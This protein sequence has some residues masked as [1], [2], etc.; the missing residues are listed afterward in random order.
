MRELNL[1]RARR[2]R[3][4]SRVVR[5]ACDVLEGRH[6]FAD[7]AFTGG[8]GNWDD[9]ENWD[10]ERLPNSSDNVIIPAA[11]TV[12]VQA[13]A[14]AINSIANAGKLRVVTGGSL[15]IN[16]GG[17]NKD[18]EIAGGTLFTGYS[19]YAK[20]ITGN[21]TW[22]D[23]TLS[24]TGDLDV[25][26][27]AQLS[28]AASKFLDVKL[29]LGGTLTHSGSGALNFVSGNSGLRIKA[30][31]IYTVTGDADFVGLVNSYSTI[32][33]QGTLKKTGPGETLID[34]GELKFVMDGGTVDATAGTIA[35]KTLRGDSFNA[36][37]N[38]S[39][40]A[41][42]RF[43]NGNG[44]WGGTFTGS[45]AGRVEIG[46]G[47][48][49]T[50]Y[51][52]GLEFKFASGLLHVVGGT[53]QGY[54]T[55]AQLKNSGVIQLEG[56]AAKGLTGGPLY[57]SGTVII[58][59]TGEVTLG[60]FNNL[61]GGVLAVGDGVAVTNGIVNNAGTLRKLA[62][63]GEA[64][65]GIFVTVNHDGG[66]VDV[67]GGALATLGSGTV[68]N[69]A[70]DV[71]AGATF[72]P[73]RQ[74]L[75][76]WTGT[77]SGTGGGKVLVDAGGIAAGT[78]GVILKFA[79]G[80]LNFVGGWLAGDTG[81]LRNEGYLQVTGDG[82]RTFRAF[83]E[84]AGT[85]VQDF[86]GGI[87]AYGF[88]V[89]KNLADAVWEVRNTGT[90]N[91]IDFQNAGIF[92]KTGAADNTFN[93]QYTHLAGAKIQVT[94]G[95][96][97][98]GRGSTMLPTQFEVSA[99]ATLDFAPPGAHY[100][101]EGADYTLNGTGTVRISGY[102]ANKDEPNATTG[103]TFNIPTLTFGNGAYFLGP[104]VNKGTITIESGANWAVRCGGGKGF[105]NQGTIN[106][107]GDGQLGIDIVGNFFNDGTYNML[108]DGDIQL[109]NLN[110]GAVPVGFVNTGTFRKSGGTGLS[111]LRDPNGYAIATFNNTGTVEVSSGTLRLG[112]RVE[113]LTRNTA[114]TGTPVELTGGTWIVRTGGT[115]EMPGGTNISP[116][117][118]LPPINTNNATVTLAGG[119]FEQFA[120]VSRNGGTL[121]LADRHD[122]TTSASFTNTG[123]LRPGAGST[124]TI[125][126]GLT[127]GADA[128]LAFPIAD[129]SASGDFGKIAVTGVAAI[130]G[131]SAI[132][133]AGGFA[134][135]PG[136][137]YTLMTF[138][139]RT[140]DFTDT[141]GTSEDL[142][143]A[144]LPTSYVLNATGVT[145]PA[146]LAVDQASITPPA[147]GNVGEPI[148]ISYTV[149]NLST[150]AAFGP[151]TDSIY[152]SRN[153]TFEPTDVLLGRLTYTG[154][155][156]GGAAYAQNATFD[157]PG[158]PDDQYYVI[159]I[160]DSQRQVAQTDRTNDTAASTERVTTAVP[161]L[162][163]G[164]TLN[165]T[166]R[167]GQSKWF[168]VAKPTDID[169]I[170]SAGFTELAQA[171]L[172][173]SAE[174]LPTR[175]VYEFTASDLFDLSRKL[176][177]SLMTDHDYYVLV[178]GRE[179]AGESEA[180]TPFTLRAD[181]V[182][183]EIRSASPNL[184]GNTGIG[185]LVIEGVGF[186]PGSTFQLITPAGAR[187]ASA[188]FFQNPTTVSA[189]FDF[190][191]L[192]AGAYA[193]RV[194]RPDGQ[195]HT[196]NGAVTVAPT[197]A[198]GKAYVN[199][200]APGDIRQGRAFEVVVE[201]GNSGG[202]DIPAPWLTMNVTPGTTWK[203]KGGEAINARHWDFLGTS[204]DGLA[205]V[206][207]PGQRVRLTFEVK[208]ESGSAPDFVVWG[209]TDRQ[210]LTPDEMIELFG[211]TPGEGIWVDVATELANRF[212]TTIQSYAN[213]LA[214]Q[215]SRQSQLGNYVYDVESLI[216]GAVFRALL[217]S[218]P[219]FE[220]G[221]G[222][223]PTT[224]GGVQVIGAT[225][226][227]TA[228]RTL[229]SDPAYVPYDTDPSTDG[230]GSRLPDGRWTP[231]V[232]AREPTT[233][234]MLA[235]ERDVLLR[236][237]FIFGVFFMREE[238]DQWITQWYQGT[239]Q[240]WVA[241]FDS[242]IA[243]EMLEF[244]Q[245]FSGSLGDQT[246]QFWVQLEDQLKNQLG[247]FSDIPQGTS[248][249]Q[250]VPP[251][252]SFG[253]EF[254]N[255]KV[256]EPGNVKWS[257]GGSTLRF[258]RSSAGNDV[259]IEVE[260]TRYNTSG[261]GDIVFWKAKNVR[262]QVEDNFTIDEHVINKAAKRNGKNAYKNDGGF[263]TPFYLVETFGRAKGLKWFVNML[264]PERK[265]QVALA[266]VKIAEDELQDQ[267][268]YLPE[269]Q[270][271]AQVTLSVRAAFIQ[272]RPL[273]PEEGH[274]YTWSGLLIDPADEQSPTIELAKGT[275]I[276][277]VKAYGKASQES[278]VAGRLYEDEA[279][280]KV[281][282]L[283]ESDRPTPKPSVA[284]PRPRVG[285]DPN[286]I[287]GP[288]GY[289][290]TNF[291]TTD[292]V[293]PYKIRF[294]NL[295]TADAAAQDVFV[296][297]QL[298]SDLDWTTFELGSFGFGGQTY[299]IP[300][301][302]QNYITRIDRTADLG[303]LVDVDIGL[304]PLTGQVHWT[305]RSIDPETGDLTGDPLAG[306][307]PPNITSPE[308]EG[309]VTYVVGQKDGLPSG[310]RISAQARIV[311]DVN[312]PIDTNVYVND[313]DAAAPGNVKVNALPAKS[314][315]TFTVSWTGSDDA[316]GSGIASYDLFVSTDGGPF[317]RYLNDTKNTSTSFTGE[318]GKTYGFI[319][320]A[321]DNVGQLQA[322]QSVAQ[323]TTTVDT[324]PPAP[325][326]AA[327]I[328]GAIRGVPGQNVPMKFAASLGDKKLDAAGFKYVIDFG[329][330][331]DAVVI[332]QKAGNAP[333]VNVGHVYLRTGSYQV[334]VNAYDKAGNLI[335]TTKTTVSIRT[336][337]LQAD[338]MNTSRTALYVGGTAGPDN[339]SIDWS[340]KTSRVVVRM[341]GVEYGSFRA[342][343]RVVVYGLEG[344]DVIGINKS[345]A[346]NAYVF[347]DGGN[348]RI[349]FA[350]GAG[351]VAIGGDGDDVLTASTS[352]RTVLIGGGGKNTL[353]GGSGDDILI[354]GKTGYDTDIF[355]LVRVYD[356]WNRSSRNYATRVNR[357]ITGKK[358]GVTTPINTN[359]VRNASSIDVLTADGGKDWYLYGRTTD[360]MRD[361]SSSETATQIPT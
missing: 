193:L 295:A 21:L 56:A 225:E 357:L 175:S 266:G 196:L 361:R 285:A 279:L 296:T 255:L 272:S 269:G 248:T 318:E 267:T 200:A 291:V 178:H 109:T 11:A 101:N 114:Q 238:W 326:G 179:G 311:F 306:F 100:F 92:R 141:V 147:V 67:L 91:F 309:F 104:Y 163:Y 209:A 341:N 223:R 55:T 212:G 278:P 198:E 107:L 298:D 168:R 332:P 314:G 39:A 79:A 226:G 286:D 347:A 70:F 211:G 5:A 106:H 202:N 118:T 242:R 157:V 230:T 356:E 359:T 97:R 34:G 137:S 69:S 300:A 308:G 156:A 182:A 351:G 9:P 180:G 260:L 74:T 244:L 117:A 116:S 27:T 87:G 281:V 72:R 231:W 358:F 119:T 52:E 335:A 320:A 176:D 165:S 263:Y 130:D 164:Q 215:A 41:L 251:Q 90:M 96:L 220:T 172:Y 84:N 323:A 282:V 342:T 354:G 290:D 134:P 14:G 316:N 78:G 307:L 345:V 293:F 240:P 76:T 205:G 59:G 321:L 337:N 222:L 317:V 195:S 171:E 227:V 277:T 259:P 103:P 61:A 88:A 190:T 270:S 16:Y 111:E 28:G 38:A 346:T 148:T 186:A 324:T 305:F 262:M 80:M 319:V 144:F 54:N 152:L 133:V 58:N 173:V 108:G 120:G 343:G 313:I 201:Y 81:V 140:G 135:A 250:Y 63:A 44:Y 304:N 199:V 60:T 312:A 129:T 177:L 36:T 22:T 284:R 124:F 233:A 181:K 194:T 146:D 150:S 4:R 62:G 340:S 276:F 360:R 348:D 64:T 228:S 184:V 123:T 6:L 236:T 35:V 102:V 246:Q 169:A 25:T 110:I 232:P 105:H 237:G 245:G 289:G 353:Q 99:G 218:D 333:G 216:K 19:G 29:Q 328:R 322:I 268:I 65:F 32:T 301:G 331:T 40:G 241:S 154:G 224:V 243:K 234:E 57:N 121:N 18:V 151:W 206:L 344:N 265:G 271:T 275:Y 288:T 17:A 8:T 50:H 142:T 229:P 274:T 83:I 264:L 166:I 352:R 94:G 71:A 161:L 13:A 126:G 235:A 37:I 136:D 45:G 208:W 280:V 73:S 85:V 219:A 207:R 98:L 302:R 355:S 283:D 329:D 297:Q 160:A 239:G 252:R 139:S 187:T 26:G 203:L 127:S 257:F 192:A 7:I 145:G 221:A 30:G 75:N 162:T 338:E 24:G 125:N 325:T 170:L 77:M 249:V 327:S 128:T 191:G 33:I 155:L 47:F 15:T 330:G 89:V 287:T 112:E 53:I 210:R 339:I 256:P 132:E 294:E 49:Y 138:A 253:V 82:D 299:D 23:G 303:L 336:A 95:A 188:T 122:F 315:K 2:S 10:L 46:S 12:T 261:A 115:L 42:V 1:A 143:P 167:N 3:S 197:L 31:S 258:G 43:D 292:Q 204:P 349:T 174:V 185:T 183:A 66:R 217:D 247:V 149:E 310:R 273:R 51:L 113:Q 350:S 153:D 68:N 254:A 158:V 189:T 213:H 86:T 131:T 48:I 159:V 93:S 214:T 20:S 334:K